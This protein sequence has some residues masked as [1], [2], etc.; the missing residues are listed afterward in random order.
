MILPCFE[1]AQ[2]CLY[3]PQLFAIGEKTKLGRFNGKVVLIVTEI[4]LPFHKMKPLVVEY[5]LAIVY[6]FPLIL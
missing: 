2:V 4:S 1:R 6:F 3:Q 5:G